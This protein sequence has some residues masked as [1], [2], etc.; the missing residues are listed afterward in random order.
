M[1]AALFAKAGYLDASIM[2]FVDV[3]DNVRKKIGS[4]EYRKDAV[5]YANRVPREI[6]TKDVAKS[7]LTSF[8][9]ISANTFEGTVAAVYFVIE[10]PDAWGPVNFYQTLGLVN[11]SAFKIS[12]GNGYTTYLYNI[13]RLQQ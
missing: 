11:A 4:L 12:L 6:F 9:F 7:Y 5:E 10:L 1:P 8:E 2:S 3:F 13:A